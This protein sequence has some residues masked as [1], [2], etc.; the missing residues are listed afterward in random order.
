MPQVKK[1]AQLDTEGLLGQYGSMLGA[2]QIDMIGTLV[3]QSITPG[4]AIPLSK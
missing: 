3:R 1:L 4:T 2:S